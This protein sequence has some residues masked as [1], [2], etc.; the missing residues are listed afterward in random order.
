MNEVEQRV[1][2]LIKEGSG[3]EILSSAY[4]EQNGQG[5]VRLTLRIP[6]TAGAKWSNFMLQILPENMGAY[7]VDISRYYYK[8]RMPTGDFKLKYTWRIIV[9]GVEMLL[10]H[11]DRQ[12]APPSLEEDPPYL[13]TN[14]GEVPIIPSSTRLGRGPNGKGAR[15]STGRGVL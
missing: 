10:L 1:L 8:Q 9:T 13:H 4:T 14:S 11:L 2:E 5:R 15:P 6:D 3:G 7:S 12:A